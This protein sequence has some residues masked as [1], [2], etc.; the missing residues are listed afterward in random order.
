MKVRPSGGLNVG[1]TF[2]SG[3]CSADLQVRQAGERLMQITKHHL[4]R[5]TLVATIVAGCAASTNAQSRRTPPVPPTP[6][7]PVAPIAPDGPPAPPAPAPLAPLP[8]LPPFDW[9]IDIPF[10]DINIDL[11]S[12]SDRLADLKF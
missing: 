10:P 2:R 11:S 1:P 7:A 6:P 5:A 12:L 9:D 3:V 4:I 8:P